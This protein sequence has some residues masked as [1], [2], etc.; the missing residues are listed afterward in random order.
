MSWVY[1][2]LCLVFLII[3]HETG[4]LVAAK[5][6]GVKVESFSVGFGPVLLH[7]T[8]GGTDYRL[9]LIPLGGYCGLKGE[10]DFQKALDE[11][12]SKIE[13][14][15]DSLYGIHP[16]K[17]AFIG[18]NGPFFNIIIAVLCFFMINLIGYEYKTTTNHI[19]IPDSSI[20]GVVS[21]AKDAGLQD[22]DKIIAINNKEV[23]YFDDIM[24]GIGQHPDEDVLL[25]IERDGKVF[26]LTVHTVLDKKTGTG[27]IG[28]TNDLSKIITV[29]TP[30][31]NVFTAFGKGIL[32][33]GE[34]IGLTYK[35]IKILFMGIDLKNS[36]RGP[37]STTDMLG[38]S[39]QEG[40]GISAKIGFINLFQFVALISVSLG[41]MN[42]LPIPIL[43][44]G[45]ILIAL[46]ETIFR[47]KI[48]PSIQYY[49]QFIGLAF[50][51]AL[52]LLGLY[53]DISYFINK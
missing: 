26:E 10:K 13:G 52:F 18:F 28:I 48:K 50:V 22:G 23:L 42:L 20:E 37:V 31:Y 25:K 29:H 47:R 44:G 39:I 32:D 51:L 4:H 38:S 2:I 9:S 21:V 24:S 43:D 14:E 11:K 16:L 36:V 30:K 5:M 3:F 46:I 40:F 17:R 49:I 35:S 27:K 41:I 15:K 6:C 8:I 53:G 12:L 7:K 34:M 19:L 1:G 45:L 33:T